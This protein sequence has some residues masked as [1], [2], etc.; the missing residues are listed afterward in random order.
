MH[1]RHIET[2]PAK[3]RNQKKQF[4]LRGNDKNDTTIESNIQKIMFRIYKKT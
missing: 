2:F 1:A 3:H 4:I